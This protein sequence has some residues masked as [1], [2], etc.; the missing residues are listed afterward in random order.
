MA[1]DISSD[2]PM[3]KFVSKLMNDL[4]SVSY[5]SNHKMTD[6]GGDTKSMLDKN[7]LHGIVAATKERYPDSKILDIR[8]A[9]RYKL[10]NESKKFAM[11]IAKNRVKKV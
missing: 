8:L 3:A 10:N 5:M 2:Q 9:I 7:M 1:E 4:F 11:A 6:R